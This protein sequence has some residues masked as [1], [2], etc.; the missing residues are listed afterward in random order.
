MLLSLAFFAGIVA[1]K[2]CVV[3]HTDNADDT[4]AIIKAFK[5]CS[6]HADIVFDAKYTYNAYTP[7]SLTDLSERFC[8]RSVCTSLTAGKTP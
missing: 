7:V 8:F 2:V 3:G 5:D 1:A 4:P 6:S